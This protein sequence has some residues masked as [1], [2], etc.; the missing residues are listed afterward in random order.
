[1]ESAKKELFSNHWVLQK[2]IGKGAFATVHLCESKSTAGHTCAVKII[3]K[4]QGASQRDALDNEIRCM[5]RSGAHQNIV[6][7][8]DIYEDDTH[9]YI[10]LELITGGELFDRIIELQSYSE[11]DASRIIREILSAVKH[12]H[13]RR[14]VH[15]DLKPE[16]LLLESK[17]LNAHV[18]L[19]DFGLAKDLQETPE[20]YNCA[21]TPGY[22]APEILEAY[23]GKGPYGDTV[24][25][26]STGVILYIL[27]H[28]FPP[29]WEEDQDEMFEKIR[30]GEFFFPASVQIS[31]SAKDII[32]KLLT[33]DPA[34]R[35]TAAQ[36]LD[37]PWVKGDAS[38]TPLSSE[39]K[40]ELKKWTARRRFKGAINAVLALNKLKL[41][42][43]KPGAKKKVVVESSVNDVSVALPPP[44]TVPAPVLAKK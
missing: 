19:A 6:K 29:F 33:V 15:R 14:I 3:N 7:L 38:E 11:K 37:H 25:L 21:G 39:F 22:L 27:V 34:K 23:Y 31:D 20:L 9:I 17:D 43:P 12:L 18:K 30:R 24:D 42:M 5:S 13:D 16:N 26:W 10:V 8:V 40:D 44:P 32:S 4:S 2:E 41:V 36:A 28:G 35:L 1:M